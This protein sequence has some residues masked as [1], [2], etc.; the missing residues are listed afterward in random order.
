MQRW[1]DE[2]KE[3][4]APSRAPTTSSGEPVYA[5]LDG[6]LQQCR[7]SPTPRSRCTRGGRP[8]ENALSTLD[9]SSPRCCASNRSEVLSYTGATDELS[10]NL[11]REVDS[12]KSGLGSD[13][14]CV[15]L[16]EKV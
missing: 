16:A 5:A 12:L 3:L 10:N 6:K 13:G 2:I 15:R 4:R 11:K 7:I 8:I 9:T 14:Y 1:A